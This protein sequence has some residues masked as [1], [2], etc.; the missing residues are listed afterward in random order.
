MEFQIRQYA[1]GAIHDD[2]LNAARIDGCGTF[3]LYTR[4]AFPML[5]P[6]VSFLALFTFMNTWNDYLWPLIII[7]KPEKYTIQVA[8]SQLNGAYYG[9][10]YGMIMAGTLLATLPLII[11][12]LIFSRH[13]MENISAGAIKD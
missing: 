13:F 10:N 1:E 5:L 12:F 8:L 4:I 2:L 11:V 3:R 7:S 6:A 9:I